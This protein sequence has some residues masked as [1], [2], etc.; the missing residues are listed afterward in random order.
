M[1][2]WYPIPPVQT[3]N[4]EGVVGMPRRAVPSAM[5]ARATGPRN[6]PCAAAGG[7]CSLV[8]HV[9]EPHGDGFNVHW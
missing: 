5:A 9:L 8:L 2:R 1:R 6:R 3:V 4:D 7:T